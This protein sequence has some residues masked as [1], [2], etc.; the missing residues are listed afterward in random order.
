MARA[1]KCQEQANSAMWRALEQCHVDV[2]GRFDRETG[3][4]PG[5]ERL[6]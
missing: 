3:L 6:F 2:M 5:Y 1:L 4:W